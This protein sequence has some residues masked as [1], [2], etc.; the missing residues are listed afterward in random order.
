MKLAQ[1]SRRSGHLESA[2]VA[3][4]DRPFDFAQDRLCRRANRHGPFTTPGQ[5]TFVQ[6]WGLNE[7]FNPAV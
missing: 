1:T 6:W 3:S 2:S 4:A 5:V 7:L